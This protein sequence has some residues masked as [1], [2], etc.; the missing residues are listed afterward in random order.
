MC[1][2][3]YN[4]TDN[5]LNNRLMAEQKFEEDKRHA[6]ATEKIA[7]QTL[8]E[9]IAARNEAKKKDEI[10][11]AGQYASLTSGENLINAKRTEET[12]KIVPTDDAMKIINEKAN[13]LGN[14][15]VNEN[16]DLQKKINSVSVLNDTVG[17]GKSIVTDEKSFQNS[18]L[19]SDEL[20]SIKNEIN[21]T[22]QDLKNNQTSYYDNTATGT[23]LPDVSEQDKARYKKDFEDNNAL[24]SNKL[25]IL[26]H[27]YDVGS[28]SKTYDQ[29][30]KDSNDIIN[31]T[32]GGE[33]GVATKAMNSSQSIFKDAYAKEKNSLINAGGYETK[34]EVVEKDI[35]YTPSEIGSKVAQSTFEQLKKLYPGEN[36][37]VLKGIAAKY[38]SDAKD[39]AVAA[40][41]LKQKDINDKIELK[42]KYTDGNNKL[43]VE[44]YKA[45]LDMLKEKRKQL[46]DSKGTDK[47]ESDDKAVIELDDK[48]DE[49]FKR[50]MSVGIK[51]D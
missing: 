30:V 27:K 49:V 44:K 23:D 3:Q 12:G 43:E 14:Q 7:Q 19:N 35:N 46:T 29:A 6:L 2:C 32:I 31:K 38:G 21:K 22:K 15:A 50:M 47:F 8:N 1:N 37:N 39:K 45:E 9:T 24:L 20:A 26:Q 48:I 40:A 34:K 11:S 25:K 4:I 42:L 13:T 5:E 28:G 10:S 51:K 17:D 18:R 33:S 36:E 41:T 16:S